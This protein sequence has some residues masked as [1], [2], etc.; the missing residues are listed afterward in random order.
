MEIHVRHQEMTATF[1][2]SYGA[3]Y[4]SEIFTY[5][6]L[7]NLQINFMTYYYYYYISLKN[8]IHKHTHT[9]TYSYRKRCILRKFLADYGG[10][11][12]QNLQDGQASQDIKNSR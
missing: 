11:Q 9:Y 1:D 6:I 3:V 4:C 7:F 8:K 10:Y 5:I 12:V 2:Y